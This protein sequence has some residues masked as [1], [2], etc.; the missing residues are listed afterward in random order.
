MTRFNPKM[1]SENEKRFSCIHVF[2][3]KMKRK[4]TLFFVFLSSSNK[5]SKDGCKIKYAERKGLS[6]SI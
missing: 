2:M 1:P 3:S 4:K 6:Y 5:A